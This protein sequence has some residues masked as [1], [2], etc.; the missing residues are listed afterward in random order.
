M[1]E[2]EFSEV[3]MGDS[4]KAKKVYQGMDPLTAVDIARSIAW[5]VDQPVHV[6]IQEMVIMPTD[7]ADVGVVHRS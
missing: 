3:R 2:T 5:A 6:N 1:V 7:Q 4:D